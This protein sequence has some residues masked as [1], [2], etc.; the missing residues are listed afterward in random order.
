[1]TAGIGP[2]DGW[3]SITVTT[4]EFTEVLKAT[5]LFTNVCSLH[6]WRLVSYTRKAGMSSGKAID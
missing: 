5:H 1:M 6:A 4:L 2:A 3:R